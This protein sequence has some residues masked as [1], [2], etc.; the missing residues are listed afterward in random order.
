[1][2]KTF[3]LIAVTSMGDGWVLDYS[4]SYEDCVIALED[5]THSNIF[6]EG[7]TL[8]CEKEN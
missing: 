2:L 8:I 4:L 6:V 5:F 3:A 7:V 1:M